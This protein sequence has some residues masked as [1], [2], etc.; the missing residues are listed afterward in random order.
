MS[1]TQWSTDQKTGHSN[2]YLLRQGRKWSLECYYTTHCLIISAAIYP[3][4]PDLDSAFSGKR[5]YWKK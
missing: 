1:T 5:K 3:K 4:G 2:L